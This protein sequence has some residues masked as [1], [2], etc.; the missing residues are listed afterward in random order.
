MGTSKAKFSVGEI[1]HH[2][3]F[4]YRGVIADVDPVFQGTEEWYETGATS[5]PPKDAPWYHVLVHGGEHMT[6]V[7]ERNLENDDDGGLIVHPLLSHFF[8]DHRDGRYRAK[9]TLN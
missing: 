4:D 5:N 3:R 8:G 1:I 6:Y 2:R 9:Q 7:V